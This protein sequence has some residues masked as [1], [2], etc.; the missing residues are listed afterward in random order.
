MS[1]DA[2]LPTA[3]VFNRI[4]KIRGAEEGTGLIV[5][6]GEFQYLVTAGHIVGNRNTKELH[7]FHDGKWN[8]YAIDVI[9]FSELYDAIVVRLPVFLDRR[10]LPLSLDAAGIAWGQTVFFLGYPFGEY[11]VASVF[12]N[13]VLPMPF[14]KRACLSMFGTPDRPQTIILDGINNVGF[15]GGPIVFSLHGKPKVAGI[16]TRLREE[17]RLLD[18]AFKEGHVEKV[19]YSQNTGLI[20]GVGAKIITDLIKDGPAGFPIPQQT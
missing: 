2:F 10:P 1:S 16:V 3:E 14:V 9:G 20:Y 5:D 8:P 4:L 19:V 6:L 13:G 17:Q 12:G 7:I 18:Y 15:S 11:G